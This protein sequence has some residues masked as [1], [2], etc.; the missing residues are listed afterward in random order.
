MAGIHFE[1]KGFV[2]DIIVAPFNIH[3]VEYHKQYT[4]YSFL[5]KWYQGKVSVWKQHVVVIKF[6]R[7]C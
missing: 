2:L 4:K 6:N 1:L 5:W 3:M 7:G